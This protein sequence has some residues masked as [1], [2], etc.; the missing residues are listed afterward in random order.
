MKPGRAGRAPRRVLNVMFKAAFKAA[1]FA[2]FLCRRQRKYEKTRG[3]VDRLKLVVGQ[4][5]TRE[6]PAH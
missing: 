4:K 2:Y 1:F 5:F 3:A 6:N